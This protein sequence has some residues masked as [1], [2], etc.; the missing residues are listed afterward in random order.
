MKGPRAS[1][2]ATLL[3]LLDGML[4]MVQS[5]ALLAHRLLRVTASRIGRWRVVTLTS[6][7]AEIRFTAQSSTTA[8]TTPSPA[9][10]DAP[11]E[12]PM[13][14]P[15]QRQSPPHNIL[16]RI[17]ARGGRP[18]HHTHLREQAAPGGAPPASTSSRSRSSTK[19]WLGG[20]A[21]ARC[22]ICVDE[23][24]KGDKASVFP[25]KHLFHGGECVTP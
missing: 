2:P 8:P 20:E 6:I 15:Q 11:A 10:N 25:R 14:E 3:I 4:R 17:L 19:R 13:Q 23:M 18:H 9:G 24:A 16:R 21:S 5:T 22:V 1:L 12:Q 7:P